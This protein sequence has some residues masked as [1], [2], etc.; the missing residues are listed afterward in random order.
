MRVGEGQFQATR[1][2]L[3]KLRLD[4]TEH[5]EDIVA[6]VVAR[7]ATG[8][9]RPLP[10]HNDA[11]YYASTLADPNSP[12]LAEA[13]GYD[14]RDA[15]PLTVLEGPTTWRPRTEAAHDPHELVLMAWLLVLL[16]IVALIAGGGYS[17]W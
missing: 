17:P 16:A 4:L 9:G 10:M 14:H 13:L 11:D 6:K 7:A 3:L 12:L 2:D 8:S 1:L 15:D 5:D